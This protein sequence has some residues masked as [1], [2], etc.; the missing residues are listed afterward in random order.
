MS[1]MYGLVFYFLQADSFIILFV[2]CSPFASN[3]TTDIVVS[4]SVSSVY[5]V[6]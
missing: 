1:S 6:I 5:F 2:V 4:I 3:V